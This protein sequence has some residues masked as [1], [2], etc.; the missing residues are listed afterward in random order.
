[1]NRER[2]IFL[3]GPTASG[4]TELACRL[5]E[6]IGEII[7]VDSM[8]VYREMDL[9]TAKPTRD[10]RSRVAHHLIDIVPPDGGFSAGDFRRLALKA[11]EEVQRRGGVPF[12][13]GG[14]GLYFRALEYDLL[15]APPGDFAVRR[16]LYRLEEER[17]G[18]LHERLSRIDPETAGRLHPNDLV[19]IARALEIVHQAGKRL[20]DLVLEEKVRT[21]APLKIGISMERDR[22]YERIEQRCSQMV[23]SGLPQEVRRLLHM[24]CTEENP[25][26][27]GLGYSHYIQF[28]KGC[29]SHEETVRRFIR[30]TRRYAKRQLTWFRG[31]KDAVWFR[32]DQFEAIK[33]RVLSF[34]RKD[35]AY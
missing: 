30:D 17:P 3:F 14:T 28:F 10:Q 5:A 2:I 7:S 34:I 23:F 12:L 27:K 18:A 4:K 8:Q 33:E 25:S 32:P 21:L 22:L 35:S 1:M 20:S 11:I 15:D 13:V 24:G 16:T 31:E 6:G 29:V 19:R 26:M 9:G